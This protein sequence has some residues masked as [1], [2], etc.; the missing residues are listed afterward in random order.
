MAGFDVLRQ[1][2]ALRGAHRAGGRAGRRAVARPPARRWPCRAAYVEPACGSSTSS[3][4][5]RRPTRRSSPTGRASAVEGRRDRPLSR[6]ARGRRLPLRRR[7][8]RGRRTLAAAQSLYEVVH[9]EGAPDGSEG[10]HAHQPLRGSRGDDERF[11]AGWERA[12]AALADQRGYLGTRLHRSVGDTDL[13]F[14]NLARWS[15]PLMFAR[16]TAAAR[17]PRGRRRPPLRRPSRALQR[18]R[19]TDP[20]GRARDAREWPA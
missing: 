6:A 20:R 10:R 8:A 14:V 17:V 1:R 4:W 9:E 19:A 18:R 15:S 11:V 13:R 7:R 3:R 16:A 12:R 2:R 5:R